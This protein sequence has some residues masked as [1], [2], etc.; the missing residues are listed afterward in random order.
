MPAL[1]KGSDRSATLVLLPTFLMD[2][3]IVTGADRDYGLAIVRELIDLG[4]RVYGIGRDFS[5]NPY[6]H[7]DF[8]AK[9]CELRDAAEIESLVREI[10]T[11]EGGIFALV[12]A[13]YYAPANALEAAEA[14]E[15]QDTVQLGL[16]AP[17]LL[18]RYALPSLVRNHGYVI[19]LS[20][21]ASENNALRRVLQAGLQGLREGLFQ[22]VRDA[23]VKVASVTLQPNADGGDALA[24]FRREPQSVIQPDRVGECVAH[25]LRFPEGNVPA[26][27]VVCPQATRE[28]PALPRTAPV[29]KPLKRTP[30]LPPADQIP[31]PPEPIATPKPER[32]ADAPSQEELAQWK[33]EADEEERRFMEETAR[34]YQEMGL[35]PDDDPDLLRQSRQPEKPERENRPQAQQRSDDNRDNREDGGKKR[36]RRGRRG[37]RRHREKRE[38][39]GQQDQKGEHRSERHPEGQRDHQR[40]PREQRE[41]QSQPKPQQAPAKEQPPELKPQ[42]TPEKQ[43]AHK[44]KPAPAPEAAEKPVAKKKTAKKAATKKT[45]AKKAAKKKTA[46]KKAT[47]KKTAKKK[48]AKKTTAE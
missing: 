44:E 42:P 13:G 21:F 10:L 25:L 46:T 2:I 20:P 47:T 12:H 7:P 36:R 30:Q 28:E 43:A 15:I 48:T 17:L 39:Q 38:E 33:K 41:Q 14:G 11:A 6:Q 4:L 3:A 8:V 18:T 22:E 16:L 40:R 1:P 26:E 32:P 19:N 34:V 23:G 5:H 27:I 29:L 9:V 35:K 31:E 37:G 24:K 45:A